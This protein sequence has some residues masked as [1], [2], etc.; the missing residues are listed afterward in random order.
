MT[1]W[2]RLARRWFE[3]V[4]D[5]VLGDEGDSCSPPGPGEGQVPSPS[6]PD[7]ITPATLVPLLV[8]RIA[9]TPA[10]AESQ[11]GSGTRAV[12]WVDHGDE[13]VVHLE[14]L[15]ATTAAG[16][17]L[18]AVDLETDETGRATL[19]V[20]FAPGNNA[21]DELTLVTEQLP[22]GNADL[23]ARWG[24]ILQE[25]LFSALQDLAR[26]HA[27]ERNAVAKALV[28]DGSVLSFRSGG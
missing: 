6:I 26:V 22:R 8:T 5:Y 9:G 28:L 27:A 21:D 20:P 14:S 17:L 11:E 12:V 24:H 2:K 16:A 13:V 4:L 1:N 23:A 19:V 18:I 15:K 7:R 10:S 25:A 3:H